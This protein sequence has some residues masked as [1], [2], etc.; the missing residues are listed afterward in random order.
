M[1]KINRTISTDPN[2]WHPG[3]RQIN[4]DPI[5]YPNEFEGDI[6]GSLYLQR[7]NDGTTD[8]AAR[9]WLLA[10]NAGP[11]CDRAQMME[12]TPQNAINVVA[13][14]ADPTGRYPSGHVINQ[15][16][17][18][19]TV[20]GYGRVYIPAGY[21]LIEETIVSESLIWLHGDGMATYL[22]AIDGL[23]APMIKAVN[24]PGSN[25]RWGYMQRISDMRLDGN[26]DNQ[27][28]DEGSICHGIEWVAPDGGTAPILV[29]EL[30]GYP[31]IVSLNYDGQWFDTNRDAFNLWIS[32][33]AGSGMWMTGRGG[34]HFQ[35]ITAYENKGNG[36]RPTY[37]TGWTNCTAGRNGKRGFYIADSAVRMVNCK[38]WW[39][40][41]RPPETGWFDYNSNGFSFES[42]TRGAL[43]VACDAQ[44]NYGNG[45]AFNGVI[46]HNC[47][48]CVAD[49]NNRRNG[50]SVGV[51][52][53]NSWNCRFMGQVY[54]RYN[55]STRYQDYAI[56]LIGSTNNLI[57][58]THRYYNGGASTSPNQFIE[59]I[60]GDTTSLQGNT[61]FINNQKGFQKNTDGEVTISVYHGS[62]VLINL[63]EDTTIAYD[64]VATVVPGAKLRFMFVQ[65]NTG[66][67]TVTFDSTF[68]LKNFVLDTTANKISVV[69]F[70]YNN[71]LN[72]W[73]ESYVTLGA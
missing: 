46:G 72:R 57:D 20:K 3:V 13:L 23:N 35:N 19:A 37:D 64:A 15:A 1:T 31:Y 48:D 56:K 29:P 45:F 61:I 50:D 21:Y 59:H 62:D 67:W 58:I 5:D 71:E 34:G 53:Y 2:R 69:E 43:A 36:F 65:N 54:D 28:D 49:S 8:R 41:Y 63:A 4:F 40:G 22:R 52:F 16:I 32:Y 73:I 24:V 44:D 17:E 14:G 25:G 39:S 70:M 10:P 12:L 60:S 9:A 6:D 7:G 33:C 66:G 18:K 55:D 47:W 38:A 27:V 51:S 68:R 26:R 30:Q 42:N 11:Q